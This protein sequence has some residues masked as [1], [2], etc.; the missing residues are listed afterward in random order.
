MMTLSVT[1]HVGVHSWKCSQHLHQRSSR[2]QG[3]EAM[4]PCP[5]LQMRGIAE[6]SLAPWFYDSRSH[7]TMKAPAMWWSEEPALPANSVVPT[8][9]NNPSNDRGFFHYYSRTTNH[10][11]PDRLESCTPKVAP[12]QL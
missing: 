8:L 9:A 1:V 12:P 5:S 3:L 10:G 2:A 4:H 11:R 6:R 7:Q